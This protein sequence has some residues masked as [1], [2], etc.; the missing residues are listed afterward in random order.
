MMTTKYETVLPEEMVANSLGDLINKIYK[1]LPLKETEEGSI[2]VYIPS[3]MR[4]V[5]GMNEVINALHDDGRFISIISILENL[6]NND[7][8]VAATKSDVFKAIN[9]VKAVQRRLFGD[10]YDNRPKKRKRA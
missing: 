8:D 4:E 6:A 2:A 9:I 3:L 1:I 10:K 7:V 5:L